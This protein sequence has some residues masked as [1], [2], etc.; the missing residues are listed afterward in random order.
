MEGLQP[1]TQS[2]FGMSRNVPGQKIKGGALRDRANNNL[3]GRRS[4]RKRNSIGRE[5]EQQL[6]SLG[7]LHSTK[8][9]KKKKKK[10]E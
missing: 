4:K 7:S 10:K 2:L 3:R 1:A 9:K 5:R 8:L 6:R